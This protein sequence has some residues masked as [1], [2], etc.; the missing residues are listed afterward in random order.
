MSLEERV[1]ELES[2]LL[3]AQRVQWALVV[4]FTASLLLGSSGPRTITCK[5]FSVQD[6]RGFDRVKLGVSPKGDSELRL[7]D[8]EGR[9]V[10]ELGHDQSLTT[11]DPSGLP[12]SLRFRDS[13]ARVRLRVGLNGSGFPMV[14]FQDCNSTARFTV[15]D[16]GGVRIYFSD[17]NGNIVK[18]VIE[19]DGEIKVSE[20]K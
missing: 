10:A 5:S 7:F 18:K 17:C 19:E 3:R 9:V 2:R 16:T 15:A 8:R 13:A 20:G 12:W 11:S 1:V 6:V 4:F 14:D